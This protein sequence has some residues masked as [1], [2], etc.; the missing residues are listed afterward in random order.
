MKP[1]SLLILLALLAGVL[2][3]YSQN[4]IRNLHPIGGP[5]GDSQHIVPVPIRHVEDFIHELAAAWNQQRLEPYLHLDYPNRSRVIAGFP[6]RVVPG[7]R[8]RILSVG[9]VQTV[10][11]TRRGNVLVSTV[12]A[13]LRAELEIPESSG[14]FRRRP[15]TQELIIRVV[16]QVPE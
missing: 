10:E 8:L 3:A 14:G 2:P 7:T 11:Q 4:G 1:A 13:R 9:P 5:A 15:T 16:R 12:V 6:G